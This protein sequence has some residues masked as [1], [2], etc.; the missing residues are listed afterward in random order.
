MPGE[1]LVRRWSSLK[2]NLYSPA[3]PF[4]QRH[5]AL[6]PYNTNKEPQARF[7]DKTYPTPLPWLVVA[8]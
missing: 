2:Y 3:Q 6:P 5:T 7:R 4:P 8:V 1:W